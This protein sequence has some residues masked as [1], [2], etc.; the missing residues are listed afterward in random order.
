MSSTSIEAHFKLSRALSS[1]ELHF[2]ILRYQ[3]TTNFFFTPSK[4]TN[5]SAWRGELITYVAV[6]NDSEVKS[7]IC[8]Y[9]STLDEYPC[10]KFEGRSTASYDIS[11][12]EAVLRDVSNTGDPVNKVLAQNNIE[13]CRSTGW[14]VANSSE[15]LI[16]LQPTSC[17][18]WPGE[19]GL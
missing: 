2:D 12:E 5:T 3:P 10:G 17:A 13:A 19:V 14:K 9:S 11:R 18:F 7:I 15:S 6:V 16:I 1:L 4:T 8:G